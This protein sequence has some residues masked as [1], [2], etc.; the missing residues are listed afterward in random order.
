MTIHLSVSLAGWPAGQ[1]KLLGRV[2]TN[3]DPERAV[4]NLTQMKTGQRP[5][6][7]IVDIDN[8]Q[9][10]MSCDMALRLW[11]NLRI[12]AVT[13]TSNVPNGTKKIE[14]RSVYTSIGIAAKTLIH[15]LAKYEATS[16]IQE[17]S[18]APAKP[19]SQIPQVAQN[20]QPEQLAQIVASTSYRVLIVDDSYTARDQVTALLASWHIDADQAGSAIEAERR[21]TSR[22][23]DLVL[24]DVVMPGLDGYAFCRELRRKPE[25][26]HLPVVMVTSRSAMFDR[27]RGSLAGCTAYLT[28]PVQREKLIQTI[29]PYLPKA[30]KAS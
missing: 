1:E 5:D 12:F 30:F 9:G 29:A 14:R 19:N 8:P 28:K 23:Y 17:V 27:A 26:R 4:I 11:P 25:L 7:L 10:R 24:L 21:L 15:D 16:A 2:L 6:L 20:T 22:K 18:T 3:A 13:Q